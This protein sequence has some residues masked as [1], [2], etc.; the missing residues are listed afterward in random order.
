MTRE[1]DGDD[2]S[3][4]DMAVARRAR[5]EVHASDLDHAEWG[6]AQP[7]LLT[8]Y[9]SGAEA[10]AYRH[11]EVRVLWTGEALSV[12]FACRQ[13]EPLV[14][15]EAPRTDEKTIG[16]W[17]RDVCEVFL[18]PDPARPERYFEFEAAPTG[19]WLDLALTWRGAG[20]RDTEWE[21][22]SG[23]TTAARVEDGKITIALCIPWA[24]LRREA[25]SSRAGGGDPGAPTKGE[26]WR[27]NFYRCVGAGEGRGY[28]AWRPTETPEPGFHVPHKFGWLLFEG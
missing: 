21:F 5:V 19:E 6:R 9:W 17:E 4:D 27:V 22:R 1:P 26:R 28:L 7:I 14:V 25:S 10:P 12:R 15:S 8:R 16:L 11:A 3:A 24:G 18:A 20:V 13:A 2:V 23:M